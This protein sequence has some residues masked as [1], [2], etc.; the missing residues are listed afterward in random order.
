M[1]LLYFAIFFFI[2]P[3]PCIY[4]QV[5]LTI[6][7]NGN[8]GFSGEGGLATDAQVYSPSG[9]AADKWG[10]IYIADRG[11]NVV[12]KIDTN[13]ILSRFAGNGSWGAGGDAGPA[14]AASLYLAYSIG[15]AVDTAGY[16]YIACFEKVR[17]VSPS[18]NITSVAGTGITGNSGDGGPATAAEF[19]SITGLSF[20]KSGNLYIADEGN[21]NIRMVNTSGIITTIAGTTFGFSGDGGPATNAQLKEPQGIAIDDAGNIYIADS[22]NSRVRKINMAGIISTIAGGGVGSIT[23]CLG[24]AAED[25][26]L[27]GPTGMAVDNSGNI[28]VSA[29]SEDAVY[30]ITPA[31]KAYNIAGTGIAGYF[32][33]GGPATDAQLNAPKMICIDQNGN[34]IIADKDNRRY[35]KV[36]L[37]GTVHTP[38]APTPL[39]LV[40]GLLIA[41]NPV[42]QKNI[43]CTVQSDTNEN[44]GLLVTDVLGRVVTTA[45][46]TTNTTNN[47]SLPL[48]SGMYFISATTAS[49]LKMSAKVVVQ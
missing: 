31:G 12:Q 36:W 20:D 25:L 7:G 44:A 24:C 39:P 3:L 35:R 30:K 10:N 42:T 14:I 40:P 5:I 15:M 4:A 27:N 34:I 23:F 45:S 29:I 16:V 38:P 47:I 21:S 9:V 8:I 41:P 26:S 17:K 6:A 37:D 18:G 43:T 33:D 32:G 46:C 48:P 11:N 13:G 49:G 1:K 19:K 28:Y 22:Y 2:F